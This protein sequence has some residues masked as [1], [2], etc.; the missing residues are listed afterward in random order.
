MN[1]KRVNGDILLLY[2]GGDGEQSTS[3][4]PAE[5]YRNQ[6][7]HMRSKVLIAEI[8]WQNLATAASAIANLLSE[9]Y[10]EIEQFNVLPS[11]FI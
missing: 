6:G 1:D 9:K 11:S 10:V 3:C 2:L 5:Q 7:D 4:L 8:N